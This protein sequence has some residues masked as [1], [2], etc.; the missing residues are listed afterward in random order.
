M[1]I[2]GPMFSSAEKIGSIVTT[3]GLNVG[4]IAGPAVDLALSN[5]PY[6]RKGNGGPDDR[7]ETD[8]P[9]LPPPP[10]THGEMRQ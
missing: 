9:P 6:G 8:P 7:G 10:P 2:D 4:Y 5:I 3:A 1:Q